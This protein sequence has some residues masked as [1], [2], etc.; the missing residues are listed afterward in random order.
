MCKYQCFHYVLVHDVIYTPLVSA[1]VGV[2]TI[3]P[4][5]VSTMAIEIQWTK[6]SGTGFNH[7]ELSI[8]PNDGNLP[9]PA[10]VDK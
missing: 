8:A 6:P 1:P 5:R 4:V 3:E 7:Y 10:S 2:A 9:L